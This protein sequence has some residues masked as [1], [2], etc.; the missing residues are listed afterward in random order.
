[1]RACERGVTWRPDDG[2]P[3]ESVRLPTVLERQM[4]DRRR[5]ELAQLL[6][7]ACHTREDQLRIGAAIAE[8]L[9]GFSS[10]RNVDRRGL[11]AGFV[12]DLQNLPAWAVENACGKV[13]RGEVE[14]LSLDFAPSSPR[15]FS[16][17]AAELVPLKAEDFCIAATLRLVAYSG[18]T[19]E[20]QSRVAEK[21][22]ALA[23]SLS[24][25]TSK[26]DIEA[27]A[28]RTRRLEEINRVAFECT[29]RAEGIDPAGGVSPSLLRSL[30]V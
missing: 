29:C 18:P 25:Q 24:V 17:A 28:E 3:P 10:L 6:R 11:V 12:T 16:L 5:A 30:H 4:L 13:R 9:D 26:A 1:M 2:A 21:F 27:A 19:A 22:R 20:E 8:M 15:L 14:G 23:E 7:P